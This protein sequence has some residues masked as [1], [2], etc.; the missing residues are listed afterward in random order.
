M[1]TF[2]NVTKK[3]AEILRK[4]FYDKIQQLVFNYDLYCHNNTVCQKEA[5]EFVEFI[6]LYN[7][8]T[9]DNGTPEMY[10]EEYHNKFN[11]LHENYN[12]TEGC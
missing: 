4:Y 1:G 6:N 5:K 3:Q 2:L 10:L 12:I 7:E 9:G 8:I 11:E